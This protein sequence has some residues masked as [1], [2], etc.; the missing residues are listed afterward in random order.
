MSNNTPPGQSSKQLDET[1]RPPAHDEQLKHFWV[2]NEKNVYIACLLVILAV[3]GYSFFRYLQSQGER[4]TGAAYAAAV[5]PDRLKAF[6]AA[7]AGHPLAAAAELRLADEAYA[8]KNYAEAVASYDKAAAGYGAIASS[9]AGSEAADIR[10][11]A[12][13]AQIGAA[14][15]KTLAG[16]TAEAETKFSQIANNNTLPVIIRGEA[17]F[18]LA[19]LVA[20]SG[21]NTEAMRIYQQV[22]AIAPNTLWAGR[23]A[24]QQALLST[25][26]AVQATPAQPAPSA[27]AAPAAPTAPAQQ[28]APMPNIS[29][30]VEGAK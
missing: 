23:A 28:P 19:E 27:P 8:A 6:A 5:T 30:P 22:A 2:K 17:A 21:R 12:G 3:A 14:M 13:R 25:S 10:Y 16:Q 24:E 9:M 7:H 4:D 15:A 1:P 26:T 11:F 20:K 18:H 29:F